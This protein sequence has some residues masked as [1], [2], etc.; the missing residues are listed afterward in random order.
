MRSAS[1]LHGIGPVE[2]VDPVH[3]LLPPVGEH[4]AQHLDG[5]PVVAVGG[6]VLVRAPQQLDGGPGG[7]PAIGRHVALVGT[8]AQNND[9]EQLTA[10]P[11]LDVDAVNAAAFD[12]GRQP[13]GQQN[14]AAPLLCR[15]QGQAPDLAHEVRQMVTVLPLLA[16]G[17]R[18]RTSGKIYLDPVEIVVLDHL[19]KNAQL[20]VADLGVAK[21]PENLA[22][23]GPGRGQ[24]PLRVA[25]LHGNRTSHDQIVVRAVDPVGVEG[26]Q[27]P[28]LG[29]LQE[30]PHDVDALLHP[31]PVALLVVEGHHLAG[32]G[33]LVAL[34][35]VPPDA[36]DLAL[37][38]V[39][40][41][42]AE[43]HQVLGRDV[44]ELEVP[45]D[46]VEIDHP[47]AGG[48]RSWTGVGRTA[49]KRSPSSAAATSVDHGVAT[50]KKAANTPAAATP[51]GLKLLYPSM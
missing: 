6:M 10:G 29:R 38:I 41:G 11:G 9:V 32:I 4:P 26:L 31:L 1:L 35:P 46:G 47:L 3:P 43:L 36:V 8:A 15:F 50:Q 48:A 24:Q 20:V 16:Q 39:G 21:V 45:V 42:E 23:R 30:D 19:A 7:D 17:K 34:A 37:R 14:G 22:V 13:G 49:Q 18:N 51:L 40:K 5:R 27:T 33:R 28:L 12:A 25:F 2:A 44:G